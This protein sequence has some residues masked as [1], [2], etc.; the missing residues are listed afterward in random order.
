MAT[1]SSPISHAAYDTLSDGMKELACR[2]RTYNLYNKVAP[3][4]RRM[5][6]KIP[7]PETP[8]EPAIHPL[9]RIHPETGRRAL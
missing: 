8:A 5:G 9:V 7:D 4:S 3:R 1:R 6:V 2:L